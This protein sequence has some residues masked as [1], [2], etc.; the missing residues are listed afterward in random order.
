M[1]R[2]FSLVSFAVLVLSSAGAQSPAAQDRFVDRLQPIIEQLRQQQQMPGLAVAVVEGNKVVYARGFGVKSLNS[3]GEAITTQ[4]LFH[5]ASVTKPFVATSVMQLWERGRVD[6]DAPVTTYLPYFRLA[7]DRYKSI[8]VRLMLSH[9]SGM[10]D[11][12]DYEWDKPQYDDGALERYVRSLGSLSMIAAPGARFRYSNMAYEVLGDLISKVSG[13]T[14]EDYVRHNILDPLGMKSS[15]LLVKQ[16]DQQKLTVPH[17]QTP[18]YEIAVS[19]VFPYNRMHSPSSTLYSNVMD[20]TRW[21][22]ANMNRGEL[23]GKRI[24]KTSTYDLMWKPAGPEFQQVG[25]SWF[26]GKYKD[27]PTIS[28]SGG[29]DGFRSMLTMI[30]DLGIAV[31]MMTNS[32]QPGLGVL[33]NAA[34]DV[35]LG[36]KPDP[37]VIKKNID[38]ALYRIIT[39]EGVESAVRQYHELKSNQNDQYNFQEQFL[40]RLGYNLIR[41]S[42]V[43]EAIEVLK[44]NVEAYPSSGNAYDSLAEAYMTGGQKELAIKN[45]EKSLELDPGNSNA[46]ERIK[47]M[48]TQ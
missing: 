3:P 35:A 48:R 44:L 19:K 9:I 46:A 17:V 40:N 18:S 26:L 25:I 27:H 23:D 45:Y 47:K 34:L 20:M 5:M 4:S 2:L 39:R 24:L 28:H 8:T 7:D 42:K 11:V 21:A 22:I 29:D 41:Q 31:V 43:K 14:F 37:P 13:E 6:L 32:E 10:P 15:T 30:P 16:A 33:T 38:A 36:L 1:K 12:T